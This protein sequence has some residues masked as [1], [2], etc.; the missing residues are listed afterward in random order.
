MDVLMSPLKRVEWK[1]N[2]QDFVSHLKHEY[3]NIEI[4]EIK[5]EKRK[6]CYEWKIQ[7]STFFLEGLLDN[8]LN[9]VCV[10]TNSPEFG[11]KFVKWVRRFMP[12]E[13]NIVIYDK[14]Y[15]KYM[16]IN[17]NTQ[18]DDIIALFG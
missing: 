5:D 6:Y 7:S 4:H 17:T 9:C 8:T 1:I 12:R 3:E 18:V 10:T 11:S 14:N 16:S 2:K 13:E 15:E